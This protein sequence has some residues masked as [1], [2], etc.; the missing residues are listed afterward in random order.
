MISNLGLDE[1]QVGQLRRGH[2]RARWIMFALLDKLIHQPGKFLRLRRRA[3]HMNGSRNGL[4]EQLIVLGAQLDPRNDQVAVLAAVAAQKDLAA[5]TD[6][7]AS[8]R[9]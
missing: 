9:P 6:I 2:S 5:S 8:A 3:S 1:H 7:P 4:Q